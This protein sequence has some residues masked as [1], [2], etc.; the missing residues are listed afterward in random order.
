[1][2]CMQVLKSLNDAPIVKAQLEALLKCQVVHYM[3]VKALPCH[4]FRVK[5]LRRLYKR[6]KLL[7]GNQIVL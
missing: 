3:C 5:S 2:L 4:V 7:D 6:P 1:M